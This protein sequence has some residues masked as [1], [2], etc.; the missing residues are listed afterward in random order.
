M[1]LLIQWRVSARDDLAS[2]IRFIAN[3]NPL[4]ARRMKA[5]IESSVLPASQ[6][7]YMFRPGRIPGTREIVAHPNYIVIYR[8]MGDHIEVV[9]VVHS[10]QEYP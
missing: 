1:T 7:P 4:A 3:E 5:F 6:Y 2:L 9:N 8:V 10:R